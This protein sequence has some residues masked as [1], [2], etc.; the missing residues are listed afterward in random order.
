MQYSI[1]FGTLQANYERVTHFIGPSVSNAIRISLASKYTFAGIS[2]SGVAFEKKLHELQAHVEGKSTLLTC[3]STSNL[4]YKLATHLLLHEAPEQELQRLIQ[5]EQHLANV[6]FKK[7]TYRSIAALTLQDKGHARRAKLLY[8]EMRNYHVF[9]TGKDD[10]PYAVLL[11][12]LDEPATLRA[13]TMN[14]YYHELRKQSFKMGEALQ[15]LSQLMTIYSIQYEEALVSYTVL[16]KQELEKREIK[17]KKLHYPYIGLLAL[18][19]TNTEVI[20]QI[21]ELHQQFS[22]LPMFKGAR[23]YVLMIIIQAIIQQLI[24]AKQTVTL[25]DTSP[26][27]NAFE[28]SDFMWDLSIGGMELLN[29]FVWDI[30]N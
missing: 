18:V 19:A 2:Y 11:T 10:I 21:A 12:I 9:L 30:F 22:S 1:F 13:K 24:E 26:I 15:A 23:D 28:M 8:D 7:N 27:T 6:G 25:T 29:V 16:L 17:V 14:R 5:N 3:S 20:N 4:T